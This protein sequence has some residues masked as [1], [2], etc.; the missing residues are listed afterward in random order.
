MTKKANE[1]V[2]V[3]LVLDASS[4]M[5]RLGSQVVNVADAQIKA[6]KKR[7]E[8]LDL[9]TRV[10]VYTFSYANEIKCLIFDKDVF[11]LP[12]IDG[13]YR[14]NGMTALVDATLK[15]Q[16]DLETTSQVYGEHHFLTFVLTDGGENASHNRPEV[17]RTLL[18][19]QGENW[20]VAAL[21]PDAE[22]LR[23]AVNYGFP[24]DNV[25]IW[26][27]SKDGLATVAQKITQATDNYMTSVSRG[28]KIDKT[29][30]FGTG[31][32]KVNAQTVQAL[33]PLT[34]GSFVLWHVDAD[35]RIDDFVRAN[36]GGRFNVGRGFYQLTGK[37]V[38][39]QA[40]KDV[41][42]LD[43]HTLNAYGGDAAR[44]LIG[45]GSTDVRVKGDDNPDYWIFVKSTANNRKLFAGTKLLYLR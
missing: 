9:E 35:T 22:C 39:I 10:S 3:A 18:G 21:V 20:S 12:S 33:T 28:L 7:S 44:S 40:N 27:V 45:L 30:V 1:I 37:T 17:L 16:R 14:T 43:K 5:T 29:S 42:I 4:S 24:K 38:I 2:H 15:S 26:D 32:D 11:R 8:E 13:L 23:N 31:A 19:H 6:M 34:P 25:L 36:N 41:I